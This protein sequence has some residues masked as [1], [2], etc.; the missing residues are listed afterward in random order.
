MK[1]SKRLRIAVACIAAIVCTMVAV[2][3]CGD[4][5]DIADDADDPSHQTP[6]TTALSAPLK[7]A[8]LKGP[9]GMGLA[10]LMEDAGNY[11]VTLYQSPDEAVSKLMSGDVDIAAVSSNLGSVLYNKNK[12]DICVLAVNTG[13]I[14]YIVEN[15]PKTVNSLTDLRGKTLIASGK[16]STPQYM[17]ERLLLNAGIDPQKDVTIQWLGNHSD[18]ASA[19]MAQPGAVAM[20]PEPFVSVVSQKNAGITVSLDLDEIWEDKYDEDLPMGIFIAKRSFVEQRADDIAIFMAAADQSADKVDDNP[21]EA[22]ALI[23]QS[24]IVDD[25][26]VAAAAIP[27]CNIM[28]E[29]GTDAQS[30]LSTLYKILLEMNPDS[31]GGA[32]PG[33]DYYYLAPGIDD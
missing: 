1:T 21:T 2:T 25:P 14:S 10:Y 5:K 31:I 33:A 12:G 3:G 17:L 29:A 7:I 30:M 6:Q 32:L 23:A 20:L 26:A 16:G 24:G 9:T 22:A 19:L 8:A 13:G 11:E 18:A 4:D 28:F 15:G 27:R